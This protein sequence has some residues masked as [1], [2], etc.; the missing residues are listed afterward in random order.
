MEGCIF[1]KIVKKESPAT[2]EFENENVICFRSISPVS[3]T[4]ILIVPKNH[5]STFVE[6][7]FA[8]IERMT[9]AA[10]EVIRKLAVGDGYKLVFNGGKYQAVPHIHWHLLAGKLEDS[11]DVLNKT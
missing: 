5:I 8:T 11:T 4:H 1:C 3:E 7:D 2:V 9:V 10:K 6:A